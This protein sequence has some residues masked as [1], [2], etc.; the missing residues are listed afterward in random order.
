MARRQIVLHP[1]PVLRRKAASVARVD[2]SV[3]SLVAEMFEVMAEEEGIGL[4]APQ[5]GESVRIFVTG[6]REGE[7]PADRVEARV[8][9][10]PVL[11]SLEGE[12][13]PH[14]EGCLSLPGIR[15][16]IRRP[17]KVTIEAM[18]LEGRPFTLTS[19]GFCAR[20]WQHEFDHLEGVMIIDRMST[21]DR[22]RVR[23]ALKDLEA[24]A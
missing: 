24:D 2:A 9:I 12:L 21:L 22:I 10:N 5:V 8:F 3:R 15:G 23:R 16:M 7:R 14:D 20:V 4:A 6:E 18:D 17:P 13:Q 11:T 1:D 19:D